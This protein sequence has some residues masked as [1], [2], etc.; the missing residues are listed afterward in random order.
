MGISPAKTGGTARLG[1]LDYAGRVVR[2]LVR[3]ASRSMSI[4]VNCKCGKV[5]RANDDRA[6]KRVK[7]P[8]CGET[9]ILPV[10]KS[11]QDEHRELK[12]ASEAPARPKAF[13]H[14]VPS[15]GKQS[16][17]S[18]KPPAPITSP[19]PAA[20]PPIFAAT[21]GATEQAPGV[22]VRGTT[23]QR[24]V[25]D[26]IEDAKQFLNDDK[27]AEALSVA[28]KATQEDPNNADAWA[29]LAES[30][31]H[32]DD[33]DNAIAA[34]EQAI[35]LRPNDPWLYYGIGIVHRSNDA[36]D[37]AIQAFQRASKIDP[38]STLFRGAIGLALLVQRKC[39]ESI[40]VLRR[41]VDDEPD[42]AE[43]RLWLAGAYH[44]RAYQN[45]THVTDEDGEKNNYATTREQLDEALR[46]VDL[47]DQL[48]FDRTELDIAGT[49]QNI[50]SMRKRTFHGNKIV[51]GAAFVFGIIAFA[52]G[53]IIVGV[54][55][56]AAGG[57][58]IASCMTPQYVLNRRI[59]A[60]KGGVGSAAII[61]ESAEEGCATIIFSIFF[62]TVFYLPFMIVTNFIKNYAIR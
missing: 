26:L 10:A 37:K 4:Q 43:H 39:D 8:A 11:A 21:D 15:K 33:K 17:A 23:F 14:L 16:S 36:Q 24:T 29:I 6:G 57:L 58:Y 54:Y 35:S 22:N 47:A 7:C 53:W 28:T 49:R 1:A 34:Y 38:Q 2:S 30:R 40:S 32:W 51:V 13:P 46:Y 45:W 27:V 59:L 41:C 3:G 42:N 44:D 25:S 31:F 19:K 60:G 62:I 12:R 55:F 61:A 48:E 5:L 20:Q 56:A 18:V 52:L 9:L 50:E